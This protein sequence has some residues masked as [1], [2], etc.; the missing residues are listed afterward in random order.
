MMHIPQSSLDRTL[1]DQ[2]IELIKNDQGFAYFKKFYYGDPLEI[3]PSEMPC[4][5]VDLLRTSI[6]AGPTGMDSIIQ[7]VRISLIYNKRDDI[8]MS[9][10]SEVTG[11]RSLEALAQGIDPATSE[12]ESHTILGIL[13]KN[14][15]IGNSVHNQTVEIEYG[16][17]NRGVL[18]A[19]CQLTFTVYSQREVSN[20]V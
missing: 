20:R 13:R 18:T 16:V 5:T 6:D 10:S 4:I 8:T 19:E 15:T 11:V 2:I 14:F 7:T 17:G 9:A 1:V 12:Y 3:P